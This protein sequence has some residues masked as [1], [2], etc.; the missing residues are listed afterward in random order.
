MLAKKFGFVGIVGAVPG[1]PAAKAGLSTNDMIETIKGV[2]TRDMPLAYA[3]L[4][5][6]GEAGQQRGTERG[7]GA[8]ARTAE[9]EADARQHHVPAGRGQDA[10]RITSA[11]SSTD[12]LAPG[13]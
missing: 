6:E 3:S 13:R 1:S 11:T 12:T 2:A 7:A 8:A 4:L 10:G 5:L 9:D